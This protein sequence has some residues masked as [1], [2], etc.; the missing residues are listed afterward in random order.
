L[1]GVINGS[2]AH[3]SEL[4]TDSF[5]VVIEGMV[6]KEKFDENLAVI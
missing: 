4:I 5:H 3:G 1:S 6:L 2:V